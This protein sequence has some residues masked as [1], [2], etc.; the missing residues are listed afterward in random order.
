MAVSEVALAGLLFFVGLM[1]GPF[2]GIIVDRSVDRVRLAPELRCVHCQAGLGWQSLL[3]G[4]WRRRCPQCGQHQGHRYLS[5]DLATGVLLALIGLRFGPE[6]RLLPFLALAA[7]LVVLSV[8]DFES[9]LLPN[10]VVWPSI[11]ISLF[12]VMVLGGELDDGQGIYAALVGGAVFSGFIGAAH[13][14]YERGMGRGDVKLSL[15]LGLFLGWLQPD[16]LVAVRLVFY[17][18][19]LALFGG[20]VI[21]L[22]VNVVRRRGRAEIPFGPA[23]AAGALVVVLVSPQL[24]ARL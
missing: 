24:V 19:F 10:V 8:I 21:G 18:I 7:V 2:L 16:I 4:H 1:M 13:L 17:A 20:G 15:L 22:V 12:L 23:L 9:H 6:W 3:P 11:W 14:L 5:V